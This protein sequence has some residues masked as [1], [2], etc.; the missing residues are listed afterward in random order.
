[1][2]DLVGNPEDRFSCVADHSLHYAYTYSKLIPR[3][4]INNDTADALQATNFKKTDLET[5][6]E[7]KDSCNFGT[8]VLS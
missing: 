7:L 3:V 2:S 6:F 8:F 1:M 4:F 5:N